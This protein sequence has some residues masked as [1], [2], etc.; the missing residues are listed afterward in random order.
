MSELMASPL[1]A[2]LLDVAKVVAMVFG[3]VAVILYLVH[4]PKGGRR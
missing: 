2:L 4:R 1:Y 3:L